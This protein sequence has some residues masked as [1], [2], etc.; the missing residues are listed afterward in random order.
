MSVWEVFWLIIMSFLFVAYLMVLFSII[1]DLFRDR[2]TS[3]VVKALWMVSLI[4]LPLITAVLY[5][6]LR[7]NS[8]AD[9]ATAH[10]VRAR[11]AQDTYIRDVAGTNS[12]SQIADAKK[13]LDAGTITTKE[14]DQIKHTALT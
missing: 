8:M 14:F 7:G 9:R 5:L 11:D 13:L 2:D 12:V 1:A 3:G 6:I 10:A 4:I